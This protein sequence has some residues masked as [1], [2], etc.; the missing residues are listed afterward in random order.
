[1][2]FGLTGC[3]GSPKAKPQVKPKVKIGLILAETQS[4][5][6]Q[7]LLTK[8]HEET[9]TQKVKLITGD[10]KLN[11][12]YQEEQIKKMIKEKVEAVILQPLN[13]MVTKDHISRLIEKNIKIILVDFLPM[14]VAVD[15][16]ISPDYLRAGELQA[17]YIISQGKQISPL[18]IIGDPAKIISE[19]VLLGNKNILENSFL[20]DNLIVKE[21]I[22]D[23]EKNSYQVIEQ[24]LKHYPFKTIISHFE[25]TTQGLNKF[26]KESA[27]EKEIRLISLDINQELLSDVANGN[28][29]IVD[30]MPNLLVQVILEATNNLLK[31]NIW[32]YDLEINNGTALIP[33]KYTP[34]RIIDKD[35]I[36]LLTERFITLEKNKKEDKPEKKQENTS[37]K[38]TR[39]KIK[40]KD[41]QE[42]EV[43]IPGEVEKMELEPK[44]SQE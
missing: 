33:T 27:I 32:H 18:I 38:Q 44:E 41:G 31:N 26:I 40:T 37:Q 36:K 42:L 17:Q 23:Y 35:N 30:T 7:Y 12:N 5:R 24:E 15:A 3:F 19:K 43:T 10:S 6:N 21:I 20:V 34:V 16:F 25:E 39:L 4:T 14:D 22:T 11:P 9:K 13:V 28:I 29:V 2:V 1:M 8:M